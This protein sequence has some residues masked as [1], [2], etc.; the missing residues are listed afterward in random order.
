MAVI[1]Q[2]SALPDSPLACVLEKVEPYTVEWARSTER[3]SCLPVMPHLRDQA[4]WISVIWG[5]RGRRSAWCLQRCAQEVLEQAEGRSLC[6][7]VNIFFW[8]LEIANG[9]ELWVIFL[10]WVVEDCTFMGNWVRDRNTEEKSLRGI[11]VITIEF[12]VYVPT[13]F[14]GFEELWMWYNYLWLKLLNT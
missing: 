1:E 8:R 9:I 7:Y 2:V 13:A 14:V 6:K 5:D 10:L 4:N 12:G 11:K 3:S